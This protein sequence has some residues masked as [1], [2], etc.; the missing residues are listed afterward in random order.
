MVLLPCRSW[1]AIRR[2]EA[3]HRK[4]YY[5]RMQRRYATKFN[6]D[7]AALGFEVVIEVVNGVEEGSNCN[8]AEMLVCR[9]RRHQLF[10]H[11]P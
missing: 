6:Q 7:R 2:A 8:N 4:Q 9:F 3:V 11:G 1:L 5:L 10:A